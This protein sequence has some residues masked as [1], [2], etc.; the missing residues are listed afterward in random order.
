VSRPDL[1][2]LSISICISLSQLISP[3]G[4]VQLGRLGWLVDEREKRVRVRR[5]I[6]EIDE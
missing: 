2:P 1:L 4:G 3:G 5:N 6:I